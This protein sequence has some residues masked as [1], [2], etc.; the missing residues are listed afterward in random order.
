[1]KSIAYSFN[2]VDKYK[3][4]EIILRDLLKK[5]SFIKSNKLK[6]R[7]DK[8]I[9]LLKNKKRYILYIKKND[10]SEAELAMIL[11]YYLVELENLEELE[12]NY[13]VF[14]F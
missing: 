11:D 13:S 9:E 3:N 1:M 12:S 6:F 5:R 7:N 2:F 4:D 8:Y 10:I 14:S